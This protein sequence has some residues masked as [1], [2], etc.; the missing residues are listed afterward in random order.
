MKIDYM[1]ETEQLKILSFK[2]ENEI[3]Q[4]DFELKKKISS[5]LSLKIAHL[6]NEEDLELTTQSKELKS[7]ATNLM[8]EN[9]CQ[10]KKILIS[11]IKDNLKIYVNESII[12]EKIK[13]IKL[14]LK[15]KKNRY[16]QYLLTNKT[17]FEEENESTE[18]KNTDD[19]SDKEKI[20]RKYK[21][22]SNCRKYKNINIDFKEINNKL[23]TKM[24]RSL[25]NKSSTR[26]NNEFFSK[27]NLNINIH[28]NLNIQNLKKI[29]RNINAVTINKF[30][31]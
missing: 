17:I 12:W 21:Y 29:N 13:K 25:S 3:E 22:I 6:Y 27:N 7:K 24:L 9:L 15:L 19:D 11:K 23:K 5:I 20:E 18:G 28:L 31:I 30:K 14:N 8:K 16:K 1:N 10:L 4:L 2:I 26:K